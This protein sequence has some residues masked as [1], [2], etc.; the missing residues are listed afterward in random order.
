MVYESI[1]WEWD[2]EH[3]H[4]SVRAGATEVIHEKEGLRVVAD[5]VSSG[6]GGVA[7]VVSG[8]AGVEH[9]PLFIPYQSRKRSATARGTSHLLVG[10]NLRMRKNIF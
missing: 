9:L 5:T 2:P 4:H 10:C 6:G 1:K 3:S 8:S 7:A